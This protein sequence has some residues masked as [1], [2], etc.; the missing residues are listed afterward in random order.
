MQ[1]QWRH[2]IRTEHVAPL[3]LN[4]A[5]SMLYFWSFSF[6]SYVPTQVRIR[7]PFRSLS[8]F[9]AWS[10]RWHDTRK[11]S[12]YTYTRRIYGVGAKD[13]EAGRRRREEKEE[14][15]ASEFPLHS[16][17]ASNGFEP[18]QWVGFLPRQ[19]AARFGVRLIKQDISA[20]APQGPWPGPFHSFPTPSPIGY[21]VT[22]F[23]PN[24]PTILLG[25]LDTDFSCTC[26]LNNIFPLHFLF[27]FFSP[28]ICLALFPF[29]ACYFVFFFF[30]LCVYTYRN[31]EI[32][33]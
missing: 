14:S 30:W 16:P 7:D 27:L 25:Y 33:F 26:F 2:V 10:P 21:S 15:E 23:S 13:H 28:A 3:P 17:V 22:L 11:I 31:V 20:R 24:S 12:I 4:D 9:R 5:F 19:D 29:L 18:S 32:F 1:S 6:R 8:L